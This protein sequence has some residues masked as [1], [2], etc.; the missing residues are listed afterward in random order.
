MVYYSKGER[1]DINADTLISR[2]EGVKEITVH[3]SYFFLLTRRLLDAG[4][5]ISVH[6]W[7]AFRTDVSRDD[8]CRDVWYQ[9][10]CR[11]IQS[12]DARIR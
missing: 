7:G 2:R 6:M 12:K 4:N 8:L 1:S 5:S 9:A 11:W 3:L 10:L